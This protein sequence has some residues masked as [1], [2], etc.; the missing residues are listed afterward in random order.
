M[1][2]DCYFTKE[3]AKE[4]GYFRKVN[5]LV[6]FFEHKGMD[7]INQIPIRLDLS[8]AEELLECCNK[9]LA[10]PSKAEDIL[11]TCSGFFFGNTDYDEYY[12]SDVKNV[13]NFCENTLIP[14]LKSLQED[15]YIFFNIWF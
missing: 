15:E 5:F 11:P 9:V 6:T 4:I 14:Q 1:G 13:K 7:V 3:R 2:L 8:D 12:F 10:D